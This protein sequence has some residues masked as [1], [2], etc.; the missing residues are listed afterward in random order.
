VIETAAAAL[1]ATKDRRAYDALQKLTG[2]QSWHGR[3]QAAGLNGLAELGDKRAFDEAYKIA[4]DPGQPSNLRDEA[5]VVVGA[6]GKGDPR[7]YPLIFGEFKKAYDATDIQ[8]I[9]G[10][11]QA[12]I[13]VADPRGQEAFDMLKTKFKDQPQAMQAISRFETEFQVAIKQK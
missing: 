10:G 5:L 9:I 7:A 13:R 6:T 12:I 2:M 3:I 8:G 11:I 4:N 1:G